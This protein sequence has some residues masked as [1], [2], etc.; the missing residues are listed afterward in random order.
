MSAQ[1][2]SLLSD[3]DAALPEASGSWR[4][5]ALRQVADL[6]LSRA[7]LYNRQQIALFGE[8]MCRLIDNLD[9]AQLAELSNILAGIDT[10]PPKVLV[11]LARHADIA[12][13]GPVLQKGKALPDAELA[14]IADTDR[15]DPGALFKIASRDQ[16]SER[17]TDALL[18]RSDPIIRQKVIDN[19]NARISELGFARLISALDGDKEL[20]AAI[21]ARSDVPAELRPFLEAALTQ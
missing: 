9:P 21:A 13:C 16:L 8:V 14:A 7:A 15:L 2:H 17:V 3:L 6:F 11:M 19:P 18:K 4:A 10:A 5:T 1:S 12:V 20:A